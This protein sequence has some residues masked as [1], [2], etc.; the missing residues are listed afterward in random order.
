MNRWI[1]KLKISIL[2]CFIIAGISFPFLIFLFKV[3]NFDLPE[4]STISSC[5]TFTFIQAL[6][7]VLF[8]W[9]LAVP[10]A[11]GLL[12]FFK[13]PIY[14]ILEWIYLTPI[15]L[16]PLVIAGGVMNILEYFFKTPFG[17]APLVLGHSLTYAGGMAVIL[18]RLFMAK[19]SHYCEWAVVHGAD[20]FRLILT[21]LRFVLKRDIQLISLTVFCFCLT[22]FSLPLLL[23]EV[24]NKTLEVLIYEYLKTPQE[25]PMALG[26]L[27]I[28]I[29]FIFILSFFIL[30]PRSFLGQL[31]PLPY[32]SF[33]QWILFGL[34][35]VVFIFTGL[36]EG[37]FFI[38]EI[39]KLKGFL[40]N[41]LSA[42]FL[43]LS[44]GIGVIVF[45]TLISLC[46]S[47]HYLKKFLMGYGAP[48]IV[49][50]GFSFLIF[51]H[52]FV[53]FSW[54]FGLIILF[55]PALYRWAGESFLSGLEKQIQTAQTLGADAKMIFQK[56][57][58]PQM[59]YP[60]CLL[61]GIAGFWACGDFAYT[62]ITSQGET[63]LAL[64]A[65]QLLGRYRTEQGLAVIWI[66]LFLGSFCFFIFKY[67]P[68]LFGKIQKKS[69]HLF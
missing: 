45:L 19:T 22:S 42:L 26:L 56:I 51:A 49:L 68:C 13:K 17:L 41:I 7:S 40:K 15:F 67:L 59:A 11:L 46:H 47:I 65:Q 66:I 48:S 69:S 10:A 39:L 24:Q 63:H 21:L 58:W 60:F 14:S 57:I 43:S 52:D 29:L 35:P 55:L 18:A 20:R 5:L 34:V 62:M 32:I 4:F 53:Y 37:L 64:L 25:W 3:R 33:K 9:A 44:V 6:L 27:S 54:I 30:K 50:T 61:G 8:S 12:S 28:E 38:P 36:F 31:K 16:P 2:P 23:G 1:H